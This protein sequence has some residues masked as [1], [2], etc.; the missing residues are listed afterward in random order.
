MS[1]L[2]S[3]VGERLTGV[4]FVHD[5]IEFHFEDKILRALTR[6]SKTTPSESWTFPN[7]GSRDAFCALIGHLVERINAENDP[8]LLSVRFDDG[9]ILQVPLG[10]GERTGPE[11]AHFVPGVNKAI[12]V[13]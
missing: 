3:L 7:L 9:S 6:P 2:D 8:H 11:A 5:Y 4:A 13:W 12:C 1:E 10:Q